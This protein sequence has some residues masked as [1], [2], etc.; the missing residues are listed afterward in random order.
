M[1][2][3]EGGKTTLRYVVPPN[4]FPDNPIQDSGFKALLAGEGHTCTLLDTGKV[5]CWGRNDA[6]QLG[7]GHSLNLGDNE[8]LSSVGTIP[9]GTPD[10]AIGLGCYRTYDGAAI[11]A[12]SCSWNGW[13]VFPRRG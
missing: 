7:Y 1:T 13:A 5:R 2:D 11:G 9:G 4:Q 6:G 10:S 12:G 3:A 8:P